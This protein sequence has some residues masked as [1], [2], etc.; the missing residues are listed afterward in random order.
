VLRHEVE[1][2]PALQHLGPLVG[3]R[4]HARLWPEILDWVS[5]R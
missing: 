5:A 1:R 3:P 4:A 2:G